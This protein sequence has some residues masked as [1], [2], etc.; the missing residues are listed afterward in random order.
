MAFPGLAQPDVLGSTCRATLLGGVIVFLLLVGAGHLAL[1]L[2]STHLNGC[3]GAVWVQCINESLG[4]WLFIAHHFFYEN[5]K[6]NTLSERSAY[7]LWA[8]ASDAV[9]P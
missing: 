5:T 2:G 4:D 9:S 7:C 1:A 6:N 3:Y 8:G